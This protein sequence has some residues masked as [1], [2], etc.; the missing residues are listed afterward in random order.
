M[1]RTPNIGV[2]LRAIIRDSGMS[3]QSISDQ[4]GVGYFR[5]WN[6]LQGR[7]PKLDVVDADRIVKVIRGK[8]IE[9]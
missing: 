8:G 4:S 5:I 6:W 7:V 9:L 1:K 3:V 2:R